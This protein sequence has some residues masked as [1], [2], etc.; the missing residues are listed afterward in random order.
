MDTFLIKKVS[1][2]IHFKKKRLPLL[3]RAASCNQ[4][5]ADIF[6]FRFRLSAPPLN[7]LLFY[8]SF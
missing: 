7:P 2:E 4:M 3:H 1:I 5:I 6:N 8:A